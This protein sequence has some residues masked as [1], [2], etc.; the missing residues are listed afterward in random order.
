M[1]LISL[2]LVFIGALHGA[3]I[4]EKVLICGIAKNVEKAIPNTIRS[5]TELG[6]HFSDYRIIIYENNSS[7]QTKKL[8]RD[9]AK[10]DSRVLFHSEYLTKKKFEK[11]LSMGIK[12]RTEMIARA[13]NKV[14]D[15]AMQKKFNSYKYVIW[16][17]LDFLERWDIEN[18]VDTILHPEQEWDA[19]FAYGAYDLF[20][21]RSSEWPL[22]AELIG[23]YYWEHLDRIRKEFILDKNG[24][25]KKVYSAFGGFGIYQ[26][27]AIMGCRYSGIVTQDLEKVTI[28]WLAQAKEKKNIPFLK[29][30]EEFLL[31]YQTIEL[32][33][34]NLAN[35]DQ[36][37]ADLGIRFPNGQITW[38]SCSPNETLPWTCE[39]I[40]FHASMILK[41]RDRIFI[42]P[43]IHCAP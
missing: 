27:D 22:G 26:R 31:K 8:F 25:W 6:S 12:N 28:Q 23:A 18:I 4:P 9:W 40:P 5:A 29:E 34:K 15:I 24:P 35:R 3:S 13:R 2:F 17:D 38:F 16:A 20:A 41:G 19:V 43:R 36:Y 42:N 30:Y 32:T 21:L 33:G 37:P 7:D 11:T 1:K 14:L 39:H 10:K